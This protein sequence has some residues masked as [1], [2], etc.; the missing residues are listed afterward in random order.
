MII[1]VET[2]IKKSSA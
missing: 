2:D 1:I